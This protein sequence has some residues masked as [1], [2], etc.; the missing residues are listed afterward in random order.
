MKPI[1]EELKQASVS[2]QAEVAFSKICKSLSYS[3][4][5]SRKLIYK[6]K[7]AGFD[8]Y[9]I[10]IAINKA[11]AL[12]LIDDE[13]YSNMLLRK[14]FKNSNKAFAIL[15]EIKQLGFE[16]EELEDYDCFSD[17]VEALDDN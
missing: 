2:T 5:S 13:R 1:N 16:P 3:E 12:T 8:D 17:R 6:L 11:Q 15:Y 7:C 4:Q 10:E 14:K 9:A